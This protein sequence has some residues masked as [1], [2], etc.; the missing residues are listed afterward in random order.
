[1]A[2]QFAAN[3]GLKAFSEMHPNTSLHVVA[4]VKEP[5]KIDNV[6]ILS[7]HFALAAI[8]FG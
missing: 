2:A 1:L 3:L 6:A 4:P 7:P 8:E 5:I